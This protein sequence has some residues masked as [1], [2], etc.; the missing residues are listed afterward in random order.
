VNEKMLMGRRAAVD[1]M[2]VRLFPVREALSMEL[3]FD[4]R[5]ILEDALVEIRKQMLTTIDC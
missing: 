2:D 5:Q 3:A 4:H 1:A